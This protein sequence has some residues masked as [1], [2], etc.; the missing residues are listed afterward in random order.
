MFSRKRAQQSQTPH[1]KGRRSEVGGIRIFLWT[2]LAATL[3]L[4]SSH[5][6][7]A[8]ARQDYKNWRFYETSIRACSNI[9]ARG[10]GDL[11]WAYVAR[12]YAYDYD[13]N[14]ELALSDFGQA[15]NLDPTIADAY[16]GRA[17][18]YLDHSAQF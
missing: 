4:A 3:D 14:C 10:Q 6:A 15:I 1:S 18:I 9:I 7:R 5:P 17:N 13:G 16:N 11:A 12:G 8:D 2:L